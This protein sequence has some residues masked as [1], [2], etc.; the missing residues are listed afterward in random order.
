MT[1]PKIPVAVTVDWWFGEKTLEGEPE[2][3]AELAE[4]YAVSV[5][6]GRRGPLGGGLYQLFIEFLSQVTLGEIT[7][8]ILVILE[9]AAFD[10]IKSGAKA[11][12][13]YAYSSAL[14]CPWPSR[15]PRP[16]F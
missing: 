2:F 15:L 7:K 14:R 6:R 8:V 5:V 13:N 3:K 16:P 4:S 9:G 1:E 11:F 10:P 12:L